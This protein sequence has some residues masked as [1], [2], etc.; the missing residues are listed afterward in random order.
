[1]ARRRAAVARAAQSFQFGRSGARLLALGMVL[2][3]FWMLVGFVTSVIT[4]AQIE[5]R[6]AAMALEVATAQAT[7]DELTRRVEYAESPAYAEQAAR[8]LLIYARPGDIV[9]LPTIA[10]APQVVAE[11]VPAVVALA[12]QPANWRGWIEAL[13]PPAP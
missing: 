4:G 3:S 12:T 8:E 9:I 6:R 2:V 1:M 11:P 10:D 5:R 13:F 7:R